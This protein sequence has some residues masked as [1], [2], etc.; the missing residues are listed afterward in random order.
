MSSEKHILLLSDHPDDA[1]FLAELCQFAQAKLK[2]ARDAK[3]AVDFLTEN[4][5]TAIFIDVSRPENLKNFESEGQRRLG[6]FSDRLQPNLIHFMSDR[7]LS[8][9]RDVILSPLFGNY[10]QRLADDVEQN[11]KLYGRFVLA[12]EEKSTHDLKHFLSDRCAIQ[13]IQ[14]T[15]TAQKQEAAEAVRQYLIAAKIPARISNIITNAVDELLMNA[16][17]DA[18][19]DE[20]GKT[21]YSATA[22]DQAR[23]LKPEEMVTMSVGFDGFYVGISVADGFGS[24][25]RSRLLNHVSTNYRDQDYQI[26]AG[27]AGAGL[28][29]SNIHNSGGSLIYHCEAQVKTEATLLYRAYPSYKEFKNQFKFFSAKFYL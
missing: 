20:F 14:L 16:L 5:C 25:D 19:C 8:E 29:I 10:Y 12:G 3:D 7:D 9:N 22:R 17:F 21:L 13:K 15:N 27:Q 6:L 11:A 23:N 4:A 26:R 18:P 24:I 2:V 28:G 1:S